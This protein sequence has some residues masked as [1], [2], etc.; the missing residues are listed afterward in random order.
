[1]IRAGIKKPEDHKKTKG[2][3]AFDFFDARVAAPL[4][5]TTLIIIFPLAIIHLTPMGAHGHSILEAGHGHNGALESY[6]AFVNGLA[7]VTAM[8][9]ITYY[10]ARHILIKNFEKKHHEQQTQGCLCNA[11]GD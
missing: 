6:E 3:A 7:M 1:M 2:H 10:P 4:F 8:A 5:V 9:A 11:S